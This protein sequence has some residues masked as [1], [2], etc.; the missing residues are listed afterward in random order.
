MAS[1][2]TPIYKY[3]LKSH[4]NPPETT[5]QMAYRAKGDYSIIEILQNDICVFNITPVNGKLEVIMY[6]NEN[7]EYMRFSLA[8]LF[9]TL[10]HAKK[11]YPDFI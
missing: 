2:Y 3:P 8:E 11:T 5:R 9:S 6:E 7:G 10:E 4:P 1:D